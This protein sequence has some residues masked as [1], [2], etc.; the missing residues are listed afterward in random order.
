MNEVCNKFDTIRL[1][2]SRSIFRDF[3]PQ[4]SILGIQIQKFWTHRLVTGRYRNRSRPVR[5]VTAVTGPVTAGK[6][7]PGWEGRRGQT[8]VAR[9]ADPGTKQLFRPRVL[10][11]ITIYIC[12]KIIVKTL[13]CQND[14]QFGMDEVRV[15]THTHPY[16]HM[17]ANPTLW[18]PLK[19]WAPVS[20]GDS[21]SY[22]W[23]LIVNENAAY[24]I[25]HNVNKSQEKV[26]ALWFELW[27]VV[28]HWTVLPLD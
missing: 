6:V 21:W 10:F 18:A 13:K 4:F 22:Y 28:S 15:S 2:K 8:W 7:N 3:F 9:W 20:S 16:E 25:T 14:M 12:I 26:R 5:P 11:N 19:D 17:Y 24:H 23:H 27:W 1:N